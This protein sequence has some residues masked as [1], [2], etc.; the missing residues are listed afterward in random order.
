MEYQFSL[1]GIQLKDLGNLNPITISNA[2]EK[3]SM[4]MAIKG[5]KASLGDCLTMGNHLT[6]DQ[7]ANLNKLLEKKGYPNIKILSKKI[8]GTYKTILKNQKIKNDDEYYFIKEILCD[9]EYPIK[10]ADRDNLEKILYAYE[11][12]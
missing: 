10:K 9:L 8:R 4:S 1:S 12:E 11:F 5:L 6:G 3:E 7:F 2:Q